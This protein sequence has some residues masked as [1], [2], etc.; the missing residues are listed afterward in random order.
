MHD[1]RGLLITLSIKKPSVPGKESR[2]RQKERYFQH[3]RNAPY[4]T[5]TSILTI[6]PRLVIHARFDLH[7]IALCFIAVKLILITRPII[8]TT[9]SLCI[10]Y[11]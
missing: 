6:S 9:P 5:H 3:T 8:Q 11:E 7:I 1:F 4:Q 10:M 2:P